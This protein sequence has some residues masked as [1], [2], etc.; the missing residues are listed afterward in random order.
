MKTLLGIMIQWAKIS[1]AALSVGY[2]G[3]A[4]PKLPIQLPANV[5]G[6]K[7]A[8]TQVFVPLLPT[9]KTYWR[10]QSSIAWTIPGCLEYFVSR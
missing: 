1:L 7:Q 8:M 2:L 9:C 10:L 6:R 3:G 4:S 5:P